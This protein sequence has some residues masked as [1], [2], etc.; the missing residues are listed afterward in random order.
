MQVDKHNAMTPQNDSRFEKP[1]VRV[2]M[3]LGYRELRV[4]LDVNMVSGNIQ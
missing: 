1:S 4:E 2:N 3:Y